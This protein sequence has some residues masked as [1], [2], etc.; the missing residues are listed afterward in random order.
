MVP[1]VRGCG[2]PGVAGLGRCQRAHAS[3]QPR[4]GRWVPV[5]G[6]SLKSPD[7]LGTVACKYPRI[8]TDCTTYLNW[9]LAE[10]GAASRAPAGVLGWAG[11][12]GGFGGME[13]SLLPPVSGVFFLYSL[14]LHPFPSAEVLVAAVTFSERWQSHPWDLH[15][16]SGGWLPH[17]RYGSFWRKMI[18]Q[19]KPV[20]PLLPAV[21]KTG[22]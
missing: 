2:V 5:P 16:R 12:G 4:P 1:A 10:A 20:P 7:F 14:S 21:G 19:A 8:N 17:Q 22:K 15:R 18:S 9:G 3:P 13:V 6:I 11:G